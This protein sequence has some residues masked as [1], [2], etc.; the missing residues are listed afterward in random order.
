MIIEASQRSLAADKPEQFILLNG[1]AMVSHVYK[2]LLHGLP[3]E[4]RLTSH[5]VPSQ[6]GL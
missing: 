4:E 2:S 6:A 1:L 3:G 5:H